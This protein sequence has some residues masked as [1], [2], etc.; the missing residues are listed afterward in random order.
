VGNDGVNHGDYLGLD[1]VKIRCGPA[2]SGKVH[3][4]IVVECGSEK[5]EYGIGGPRDPD[6]PSQPASESDKVFKGLIPPEYPNEQGHGTN[7]GDPAPDQ[8]DYEVDCGDKSPCDVACCL[9]KHQAETEPP[10][11]YALSQNSN[12]YAHNA[13]EKC[14]CKFKPYQ[15]GTKR[16]RKP[17][18]PSNGHPGYETV[19][20]I[21]T[22]PPNAT[23]W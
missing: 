11:Y 19:P 4:G 23:G 21:I 2:F 5:N 9:K 18:R 7:V 13:L 15:D 17:G 14:G 8:T 22:E 12:S 3:C 6:D 10:P 16:K 1:S 20:N